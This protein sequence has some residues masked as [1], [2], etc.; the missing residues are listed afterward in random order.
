MTQRTNGTRH[1]TF[2]SWPLNPILQGYSN[3]LHS[4]TL[5]SDGLLESQSKCVSN[6]LIKTYTRTVH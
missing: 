1:K 4:V 6:I 3:Q 5:L 2:P